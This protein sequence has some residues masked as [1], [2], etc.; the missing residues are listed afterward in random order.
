MQNRKRIEKAIDVTAQMRG[1]RSFIWLLLAAGFLAR[2]LAFQI[3]FAFDNDVR[4]FQL[5]AIQLHRYG[6]GAFYTSGG[7]TD[8]P[9]VYMY[10]LYGLGLLRSW[11]DW[12]VLSPMFNFFTFLPAMLADLGIGYVLYRMAKG[13]RLG[14]FIAAAWIFNPAVILISGV[15]GQ[16]ESVFV[17]MLLV[18]LLFLREKKLLAAYIIFGVAILTKPQSLFLGPVYL[19]SAF[20]YLRANKFAGKAAGN[21]AGYI[22]GGIAAMVLVSL[23]FGIAP[24]ITQLI[25]GM[26]SYNFASVNAFNMWALFGGN[27]QSL[28]TQ[29]LGI[30]YAIWGVL[31]VL[32]IIAGALA[33]LHV[34]TMRHKGRYFYLIIAALFVLIF[35]FSVKMHERYLFPGLL[36]LLIYYMENRDK[37]V[38]AL[39]LAFSVT[40]FINCVEI[41]RWLRGG[42]D[43]SIIAASTPVISLANVALAAAFLVILVLELKEKAINGSVLP[44]EKPSARPA[45]P[46]KRKK[47]E[48]PASA[49]VPKMGKWDWLF[50]WVLITVY[51]VLAFWRL[52]DMHTPQTTWIAAA[53][54]EAQTERPG[55]LGGE[56]A[57]IDLGEVTDISRF[58]FLMGARHN[59]PFR[60]YASNDGSSWM[61][62]YSVDEARVFAWT[63]VPLNVTARYFAIDAS[64]GLRLQEFAFRGADGEV[65]PVRYV[66]AFAKNLFDEQHL[67]PE[68]RDFMNSTYFD[69]IFHPRAGYE[70]VHGLTVFENTHPPLGKVFMAAS[71]RAF[72]MTPFAWRLP[73][74]LFGIF[75][76]PLLYAFAR[77]ILR[78]NH[79]GLFAAFIFTFDFMLFSQTRLATIDTYVTFFVLAMYF[80]MYLYVRGVEQNSLKK[81]LILL[82]LCGAMTGLAI[83]SKWQGVYGALGLP[84]LFFPALYRLYLRDKHQAKA[85]FFACFGLFIALPL[86]IYMLSY[87]PFV[88][89]SGGGGFN[90]IWQNQITM[91]TYHTELVAEHPFTSPWWSWPLMLRPLW[92]YHTVV[93]PYVRQTMSSIGNPAVWW[94]GIFATGFVI[95]QLVR[96][97]ISKKDFRRHT[98]IFLLVAY[99]SQFLPWIPVSRLT[100]IYHYFPSVP[101]VVLIIA[102]F[103]KN[104]VKDRRWLFA[105]AGLVLAL[106]ILFFPVLSGL[107]VSVGFVRTFLHW[108]PGWIFV[109]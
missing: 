59:I 96:G 76:I 98:I 36:F 58:Q 21:L 56:M 30:S 104:Y 53:V 70:F 18:S 105:Y 29:F 62:V 74:T 42:F 47:I 27:W 101:F 82:A 8:Y 14:L 100:F 109:A 81:S 80:F 40:Y 28:D 90:T 41:L 89:A 67:V 51:G 34:D 12:P 84:L 20:D 91:F 57:V 25:A 64:A 44:L 94:F 37:R 5:W 103:F 13:G 54:E 2:L 108:L 86:V 83:A 72:G 65:L 6:F 3:D 85:T 31:I 17:L 48:E 60:L 19:Y 61:R 15:W 102:W 77:Q 93:S 73:G 55:R 9:P 87:I 88:R 106:F 79:M 16:V 45:A 23:P 49:T 24:T 1:K 78:S 95:W 92:Q 38:G 35:V 99:A 43:L 71:I 75:M 10:V 50:L 69:E 39:Y 32:A 63:F 4:T 68:H 26:D 11:F 97:R 46:L 33:A 52:G 107:P 7:F 66:S 22:L